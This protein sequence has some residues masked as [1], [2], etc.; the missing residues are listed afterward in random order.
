MCSSDL[1]NPLDE[2]AITRFMEA[3]KGHRFELVFLVTLFTGMRQGEVLGLAW[4]CVDFD[5]GTISIRRQLQKATDS[6]G[7]ECHAEFEC[8]QKATKFIP[9]T[10]PDTDIVPL[11]RVKRDL[12]IKRLQTICYTAILAC[13]IVTIIFGILT[14]PKFFPYSDNLLNVIDIPDGSVII[15]FDSE[16]TEIG[17]AHV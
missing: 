8:M 5:R 12:F 7:A 14:S 13:A 17:R 16:V 10:D 2:D 9:D 3:I 1:L 11:K 6:T 15:T 4:D